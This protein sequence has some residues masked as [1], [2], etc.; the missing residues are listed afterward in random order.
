MF[1]NQVSLNVVKRQESKG[2]M[3][4]L[5]VHGIKDY[6]VATKNLM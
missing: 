5:H 3:E 1:P 2:D 6:P 4:N